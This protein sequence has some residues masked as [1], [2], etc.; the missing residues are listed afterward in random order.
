MGQISVSYA[1]AKKSYPALVKEV[2]TKIRGGKS[3]SKN[4]PM[5]SFAWSYRWGE[6]INGTDRYRFEA[7]SIEGKVQDAVSRCFASIQAVK[8]RCWANSSVCPTL[9]TEIEDVY[10]KHYTDNEAED[11]R[12]T[13]LTPQQRQQEMGALLRQLSRSPG[14]FAITI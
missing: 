10:R 8:G 3:K 14:F 1:Q 9:P 11:R 7:L 13:A 12:I 5:S 2:E 4:D 6:Q